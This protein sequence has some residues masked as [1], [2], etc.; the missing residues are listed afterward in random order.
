MDTT[1]A[2]CATGVTK[3]DAVPAATRRVVA[4]VVDVITFIIRLG[5]GSRVRRLKC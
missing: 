3:A 1:A 2:F 4:R 5:I